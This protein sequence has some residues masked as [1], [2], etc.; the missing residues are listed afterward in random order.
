MDPPTAKV[1]RDTHMLTEEDRYIYSQANSQRKHKH[2]VFSRKSHGSADPPS[3]LHP[4]EKTY[5]GMPMHT[6]LR[7]CAFAAV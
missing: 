1:P 7:F 4:E 2:K 5:I 6:H 3:P